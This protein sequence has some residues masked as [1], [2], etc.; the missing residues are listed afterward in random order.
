[1]LREYLPELKAEISPY[2]LVPDR[3][4]T[5]AIDH[6]ASY[7]QIQKLSTHRNS[8]SK[9]NGIDI[10]FSGDI[11]EICGGYG[12]NGEFGNDFYSIYSCIFK[13]FIYCDF[14]K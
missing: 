13:F 1:M 3:A 14:L 6:L 7:F 12:I 11:N 4:K 9:F 8:F 10:S 5:T 2:L